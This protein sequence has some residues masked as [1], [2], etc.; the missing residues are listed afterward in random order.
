[1]NQTKSEELLL[2]NSRD[3]G[4]QRS[5]C[6]GS[7]TPSA[8][9]PTRGRRSD[10]QPRA[11]ARSGRL[12]LH[13]GSEISREI[14]RSLPMSPACTPTRARPHLAV[15]SK[16]LSPAWRFESA[17]EDFPVITEAKEQ[18]CGQ[19]FHPRGAVIDAR[20]RN[21]KQQQQQSIPPAPHTAGA[22]LE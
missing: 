1:M 17:S 9:T 7:R 5:S 13:R 8:I 19:I 14:R 3:S 12:W 16:P 6:C 20:D 18:L 21:C 2:G 4:W 15:R 22:S 11:S 10:G